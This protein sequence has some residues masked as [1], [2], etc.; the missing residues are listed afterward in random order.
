M[1]PDH[2]SYAFDSFVLDP[3]KRLLVRNGK[4][5]ALTARAFDILLLLIQERH[6]L[7]SKEELLTRVWGGVVVEESNLFR[8]VSRVRRA[9]GERPEEHRYLVTVPNE[10]YRFV[11]TVAEQPAPVELEAP[12]AD[13]SVVVEPSRS[14]QGLW[15]SAAAVAVLAVVS[16]A[17]L[18][19]GRRAASAP[20]LHQITFDE[21]FPR[22]AA[23]SPD[24][25]SIAYT[26]D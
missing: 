7:V 25:Q 14:R 4:P 3:V 6:R 13:E 26:S 20:V 22:E 21:G 8:Q 10:G 5:V 15:F 12:P 16:L 11:G 17:L 9:L 23:W 18:G 2:Q 19:G 1:S 24:S